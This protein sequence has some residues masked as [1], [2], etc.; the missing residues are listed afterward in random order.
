MIAPW[1]GLFRLQKSMRDVSTALALAKLKTEYCAD[2]LA[3][4]KNLNIGCGEL[5]FPSC[6]NVD[7]RK[8]ETADIIHDLEVL[9]WP[10][11]NE[12]FERVYAYDI[13]EH[14]ADVVKTMEEIHRVL[15]PGGVVE[16]RTCAWDQEQSYTDPT[17]KHWFTLN[18]F[19]FFDSTTFFGNK[20]RWYSTARFKVLEAKR[21]FSEIVFRLQKPQDFDF[22]KAGDN[23]KSI[24]G[25]YGEMERA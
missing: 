24:A 20:Y 1:Q 10:F 21:D 13:L 23:V 18:S 22:L 12:R 3:L 15:K 17:H 16:I 11:A 25:R 2:K 6:I 4:K 9:P 14:L 5:P 8:T 19:D 7:R